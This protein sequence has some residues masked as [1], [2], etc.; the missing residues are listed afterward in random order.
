MMKT[1]IVDDDL[2]TIALLQGFLSPY[3]ECAS[4]TNGKD[5]LNSFV[6]ALVGNEPYDLICLDISMPD[7]DGHQVLSELRSFEDEISVP[8]NRKVKVFMVSAESKKTNMFKAFKGQC[9]AYLPKP[10]GNNDILKQVYLMGLVDAD[11][12]VRKLLEI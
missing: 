9:D 5:A 12:L 10:V 3:G 6:K 11:T 4:A 8:S 1:L 2:S 7:M